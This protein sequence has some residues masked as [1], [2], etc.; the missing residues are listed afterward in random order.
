MPLLERLVELEG[1]VRYREPPADGKARIG[2]VPGEIPVLLSAP[3]A[4]LHTRSGRPKE[5]EEFTAAIACLV[6]EL[7]GAHA[8]YARRRSPTD[9]NWYP[10]VPYKRLLAQIAGDDGV[11]IVLDLHGMAPGRNMGIAL[12]TL[13]GRSCPG[14]RDA[15]IRSFETRG[16]RRTGLDLGYLDIDQTFTGQGVSEQ[17]TITSFVW[18]T[19][20]VACAQLELHPAVRVVE[21]RQDATLPGPYQ[22]DAGGIRRVLSALVDIVESV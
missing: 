20:G 3:H 11:E 1:D 17:E 18:R 9:P 12:G 16:F 7:T 15:V 21:R 8:L 2:L 22:G 10:D 13:K 14:H 4:A 5:E 6:A 19:L